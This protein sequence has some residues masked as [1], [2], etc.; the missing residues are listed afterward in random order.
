MA[1]T[2]EIIEPEDLFQDPKSRHLS[3]ISVRLRIVGDAVPARLRAVKFSEILGDSKIT[4]DI[5]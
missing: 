4:Y 5:V 1:A 2:G 3:R